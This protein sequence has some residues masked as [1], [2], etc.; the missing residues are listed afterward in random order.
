MKFSVLPQP[1]ALLKL[2]LIFFKD[3]IQ[4]REL[5]WHDFIKCLFNIVM[6]QDTCGPVMFE[7]FSDTKYY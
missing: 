2:M 5:C 4:G 7:T 3:S 6:Y 1:V